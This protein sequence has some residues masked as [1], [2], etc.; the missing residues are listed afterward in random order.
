[1]MSRNTLP[2]SSVKMFPIC[3]KIPSLIRLPSSPYSPKT[4]ANILPASSTI[5]S[6]KINSP[7]SLKI[8]NC[9]E[10]PF[11]SKPTG[12]LRSSVTP[13]SGSNVTAIGPLRPSMTPSSIA[14]IKSAGVLGT[15]PGPKTACF[16]TSPK[17]SK[18]S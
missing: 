9:M 6:P 15:P 18:D 2:S 11:I 5:D 7:S 17:P 16:T 3:C 10:L 14:C 13:T 4:V 1:M 12:I 8:G